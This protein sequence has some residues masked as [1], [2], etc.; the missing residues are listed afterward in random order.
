MGAGLHQLR[1]WFRGQVG[2]ITCTDPTMKQLS[3]VPVVTNF[4]FHSAL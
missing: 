1:V 3:L 2:T 4:S